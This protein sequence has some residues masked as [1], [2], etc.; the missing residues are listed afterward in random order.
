MSSKTEHLLI[1]CWSNVL[2]EKIML[3]GWSNDVCDDEDNGARLS[4][5]QDFWCVYTHASEQA[6]V[7]D[8]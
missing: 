1:E 6:V 3:I 8:L 5:H 2:T 7:E 4:V